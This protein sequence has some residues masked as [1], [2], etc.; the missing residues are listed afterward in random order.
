LQVAAEFVAGFA[1][2]KLHQGP[3]PRQSV[4]VATEVNPV[5]GCY[6]V[7]VHAGQSLD[8]LIGPGGTMSDLSLLERLPMARRLMATL[9]LALQDYRI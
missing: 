8:L 9:L 6:T 5:G 2:D 3:H 7:S 4:P 1:L